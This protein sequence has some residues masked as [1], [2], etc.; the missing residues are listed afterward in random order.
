V[1]HSHSGPVYTDFNKSVMSQR[2]KIAGIDVNEQVSNV[3][4]AVP[5]GRWGEPEDIANMVAYLAGPKS[6]WMTV[7]TMRFPEIGQNRSIFIGI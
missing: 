7:R 6:A 3:G 1:L 4:S 2:A 5:L